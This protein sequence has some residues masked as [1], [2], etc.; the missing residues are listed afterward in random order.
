MRSGRN[1]PSMPRQVFRHGRNTVGLKVARRPAQ[2]VVHVEHGADDDVGIQVIV[3]SHDGKIE[4]VQFLSRTVGG[5]DLYL[6]LGMLPLKVGHAR[7]QQIHYHQRRRGHAQA[8]RNLARM[9][10]G[11]IRRLVTSE[12]IRRSRDK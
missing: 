1:R 6:H 12:R 2:D 4:L 8:A 9:S 7:G 3:L 11:L 5:V 10:T